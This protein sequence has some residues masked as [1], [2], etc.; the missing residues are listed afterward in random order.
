VAA[1]TQRSLVNVFVPPSSRTPLVC[2]TAW[3]SATSAAAAISAML[4]FGS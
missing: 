3:P 4:A 2:A 1:D